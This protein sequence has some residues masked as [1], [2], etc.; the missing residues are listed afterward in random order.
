MGIKQ[1]S[2]YDKNN[3]SLLLIAL[4]VFSFGVLVYVFDR[5]PDYVYFLP[6][7]LSLKTVFADVFGSVGGWFP[8]FAH[9]FTFILLTLALVPYARPS[10]VSAG[11]FVLESLLE[12]GQIKPIAEWIFIHT[13]DWC[14]GVPVLENTAYYFLNGT[15]DNKD[16]L[17]IGAGTLLAYITFITIRKK[18]WNYEYQKSN[19]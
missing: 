6:E 9:V 16:L 1:S 19:T 14:P 11:W 8:S 17:A 3:I 15:F 4:L 10:I 2:L 13:Y 18:E 7:W 12:L 5:T